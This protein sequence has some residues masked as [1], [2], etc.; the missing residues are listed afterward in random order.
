M[1]SMPKI[2]SFWPL[3]ILKLRFID[4]TK[5]VF[6]DVQKGDYVS[7]GPVRLLKTSLKRLR[8]KS[9]MQKM[10]SHGL[11]KTCFIEFTI[12]FLRRPKGRLWFFRA[13]LLLKTSLKRS[14]PS[15]VFQCSA[16]KKCVRMAH[17]YV[18]TSLHRLQQSRFLK[19]P[20]G[21][22]CVVRVIR[23]LKS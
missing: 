9:W 13:I 12:R 3:D 7:T 23:L 4:F 18:E 17:R 14:H 16:C 22:L 11:S 2:S 5:A 19:R 21:R 1:L 6:Q 20:N 15:R 10:S 8:S